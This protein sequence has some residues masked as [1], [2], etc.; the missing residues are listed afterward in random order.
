M[1]RAWTGLAAACSLAICV[2]HAGE[3]EAVDKAKTYFHA[4]AQAY[5]VGQYQAAVQ[6]FEQAWELAPRP[7]ILFS[8]AQAERRQYFVD[9]KREHLDRAINLFRQ[10]IE[11]VPQGGRKV[12]AVQALSELE[13]LATG[14]SPRREQPPAKPHTRV[15]VTAAAQGARIS[16]DGAPARS[17][18]VIEEASPGNHSV[19]VS[20]PGYFEEQRQ[21]VAVESELVALDVPLR[22]R[23]ATLR[24]IAAE[25]T[26]LSIDGR[27]QGVAPFA[28]D[29]ELPAGKHLLSLNRSGFLGISQEIE[30]KRGESAWVRASMPRSR[31]R[32]ISLIMLGASVSALAAGGVFAYYSK[33]RDKVAKTFLEDQGTERMTPER[34]DQYNSARLDRDRFR[35][36]ALGAVGFSAALAITGGALYMLDR[37]VSSTP[38]SSTAMGAA[39]ALGRGRSYGA[40]PLVQPGYW[41]IGVAGQ[42]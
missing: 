42:F 40:I 28:R 18:P 30:L 4:G 21:V 5:A 22:E 31:Q 34:L 12:D 19:V 11:V 37:P 16:L 10:Y 41:G 25:G 35:N 26:Q 13:P 9:R 33:G 32:T 1:K 15:M 17:S 2:A 29:L 3:P 6:A 8:M 38:A 24:V 20:A 39:R 23:P 36:A 27:F 14:L 7:A